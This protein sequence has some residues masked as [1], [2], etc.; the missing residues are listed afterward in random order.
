M[1]PEVTTTPVGAKEGGGM[2]G[3]AAALAWVV[4]CVAASPAADPRPDPAA[5]LLPPV[6]SAG[7]TR[8][9]AVRARS[10]APDLPP[11][12]AALLTPPRDV[13]PVSYRPDEAVRRSERPVRGDELF[14]RPLRPDPDRE[15]ESGKWGDKI[16]DVVGTEARQGWFRSDRAF[17]CVVSPITNPF[18]FEDPRAMTEIR[19]LFI[20]QKIPNSQPNFQ[21]GDIWF[22]GAQTRLAFG[23]RFSV[24]LN[25]IGGVSVNAKNPAYDGDFGLSEIWL[26][27]KVTLIRDP[28]YATIL[29]AGAQFQIPIGSG[30][31][32][33]DTGSLSIVP[34]VTFSQRFLANRLGTFNGMVSTG[35]SFSTDSL[36]SD[37]LYLSTHLSFDIGNAHRF[38]PV[39]E[40]NWFHYTTDGSARFISGEGRD[41]INFGS[42]GKGSSMV[43]G[44]VGGRVK[45]TRNTE[46]GVA[47][48]MP[49]IGNKDFFDYRF[50]VDFIWRY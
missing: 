10:S 26:S 43:T 40:M 5:L 7:S 29:A 23:E 34:Y 17:D 39:L 8:S 31:V 6:A 2:R 50:T 22:L 18:L 11:P 47:Y 37:Y 16:N 19:P 20:Y 44:A 48:E 4:G 21:G 36:R 24:T 30:S 32:Y 12:P 27:P 9:P 46:L 25:K 13:S 14:S 49:M 33:Q 35:Y 45:M 41:L 1:S 15:R 38:Y 42:L 28:E 3:R